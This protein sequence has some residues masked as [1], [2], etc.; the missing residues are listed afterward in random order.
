MQNEKKKLAEKKIYHEY[1]FIVYRL[2]LIILFSVFAQAN[3][4]SN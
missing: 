1:K 3:N 2:N 4:K